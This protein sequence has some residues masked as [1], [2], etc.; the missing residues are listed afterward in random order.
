MDGDPQGCAGVRDVDRD[1]WN[2]GLEVFSGDVGGDDLIGL[3]F[4]GEVDFLADEVIG[5]AQGDLGLVA[6]VDGDEF[7]LFALGGALEA[8]GNFAIK[9]GVLALCR[10]ADA[11]EAAAAH[12]RQRAPDDF[13]P[14]SLGRL[15]RPQFRAVECALNQPA[16]RGFLDRIGHGLRGNGGPAFV[17]GPDRCRNQ[18]SVG[19]GPRG[20]LDRHN[21]RRH[22]QGFQTVPDRILPFHPAHGDAKRL[23]QLKPRGQLPKGFLH[24]VAH[25]ENDFVNALRIVESLPGVGDHRAAGRFEKQFVHGR[26]HAGAPAGGD[27]NGSIHFFQS[28]VQSSKSKAKNSQT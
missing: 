13:D 12:F 17:R 2:V 14:K 11:V 23:L 6:V 18:L 10:V 9:G 22:G 16:I 8:A 4:D 15:H 1:E 7:D 25:D 19:A 27:K 26:S 3:K 20:V 24:A 5:A 28:K 21:L